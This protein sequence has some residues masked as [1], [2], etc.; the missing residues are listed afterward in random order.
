MNL[1]ILDVDGVL[2]NDHSEQNFEPRMMNNLRH[3]VETCNAQIVISSDWRR[4]GSNLAR[5]RAELIFYGMNFIDTTP[6]RNGEKRKREIAAY[7]RENPGWS[8]VVILDD[9]ES[10]GLYKPNQI[11]FIQTDHKLGLTE[12]DADKAVNFFRKER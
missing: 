4:S 6:I 10:A 5:L 8:K 1:I 9:L 11:L 3:I 7:L 2:N 12:E